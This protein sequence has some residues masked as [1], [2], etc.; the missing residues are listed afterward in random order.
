MP[1]A[2]IHKALAQLHF[3]EQKRHPRCG[4]NAAAILR[5]PLLRR[6]AW[7][8]LDRFF[9]PLATLASVTMLAAL[10]LAGCGG[11]T[12][13]GPT[14]GRSLLFLRPLSASALPWAVAQPRVSRTLASSRCWKPTALRLRWYRHQRRQRGGRAHASGMNAFEMQEKAVALD[15]AKIR[16]L[17]LVRRPGAGPEARRLCERTGAPQAT[18][19]DGQAFCGRAATRLEDGERTVFARGNT[20]QAVRASSSVPGVFQPVTIG[21]YHFV[22]GGIVSPVPVD[23]ARQLGADIVIAVDISNKGAGPDAGLMLGTLGQSIAIMGQK[24]GQ[25]ELARADVVIRP[26]CWTLV[27]PISASAPTP[28]WKAKSR[29]GRDAPDPRTRRPTAGQARQKPNARP[30]KGR[31]KPS[32]RPA[33]SSAA[34]RKSWLIWPA[35]A[36]P[37]RL[38]SKPAGEQAPPAL[39]PAPFRTTSGQ[40]RRKAKNCGRRQNSGAPMPSLH[41]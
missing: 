39:P 16:D 17:Q 15:E 36:P 41:G 28:S 24:L 38:P 25:A 11:T 30:S 23:A 10:S 33:W 3:Q 18:G 5:A 29:L 1:P 12:P 21:K 31:Q 26:R 22:D 9:H 4:S 35:W 14:R 20:G 13:P 34:A 7:H 27:S 32:N 6:T 40:R 8:A 37:A 19:A 2:L